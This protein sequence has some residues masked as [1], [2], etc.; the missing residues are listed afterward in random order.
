METI[1]NSQAQAAD[2]E[3]NG[4][5]VDRADEDKVTPELVKQETDMLNNNPRNEDE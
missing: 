2:N 4:V 1:K 3:Y 5:N